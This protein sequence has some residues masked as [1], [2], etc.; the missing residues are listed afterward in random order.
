MLM[1]GNLKYTI[2]LFI[3]VALMACGG[4]DNVIQGIITYSDNISK[5]IKPGDSTNVYLYSSIVDLQDHHN[6]YLKVSPTAPDGYYSLFPLESGP[7]YIFCERLDSA[8]RVEYSGG[9]ST[10]VS[11]NET[12]LV[13]ITMR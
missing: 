13:N 4:N 12:K 7:Y 10:N 11:G 6:A 9:L 2:A 5:E 8:G 1:I 3:V